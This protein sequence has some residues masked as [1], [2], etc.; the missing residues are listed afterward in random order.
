MSTISTHVLDTALGKPA[1]DVPVRLEREDSSDR[2]NLIGSGRTD[3]NGRCAW[4]LGEGEKLAAG[5]YRLTFDTRSYFTARKIEGLYPLVQVI[6]AVREGDG[7][8]HIPLLL[9]PNGYTTYRGS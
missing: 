4:L 7:H 9:S 5:N 3:A 8:F 6:F 2:W 1:S